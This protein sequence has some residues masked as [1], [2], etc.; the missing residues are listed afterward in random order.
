MVH[1]QG[2][3]HANHFGKPETHCLNIHFDRALT[4]DAAIR[5]LLDDYRR[6]T[7]PDT[8]AL[9]RRIERELVATDT[10]A[11]LALQAA[12]LELL[13]SACRQS[14]PV[15]VPAWLTCIFEKLHDEPCRSTSLTELATLAGVH[16][17]HL[18]RVFH[19]A[20]GCTIGD[21]LRRL[22][23]H[24]ACEALA[25]SR[26]PI[27]TIALDAGF[28]DQSHFSRVFRRIMGETP[29]AWR[30]RTQFSS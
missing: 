21:Y 3:R 5:R 2:H 14:R 1:P 20:S 12:T 17:A 13:A 23:I 24:R 30:Q 8:D 25:N 28:A 18:A 16:P 6:L 19:R 9:Q 7:L 27:A 29:R 22:R 11:P 26:R 10:A 15:G 4:D